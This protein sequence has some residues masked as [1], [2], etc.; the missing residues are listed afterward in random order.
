[1]VFLIIYQPNCIDHRIN[2]WA[3]CHSANFHLWKC[4]WPK[5]LA[6]LVINLV[7]HRNWINYY[8]YSLK[9]INPDHWH[10]FW[11]FPASYLSNRE[12]CRGGSIKS[13]ASVH[14]IVRFISL[15]CLWPFIEHSGSVQFSSELLAYCNGRGWLL[16]VNFRSGSDLEI[17]RYELMQIDSN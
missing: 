7:K 10:C 12:Y 1:M 4:F 15:Y 13:V 16:A 8:S 3:K 17:D 11:L 2:T 6:E 14:K 5:F 9:N